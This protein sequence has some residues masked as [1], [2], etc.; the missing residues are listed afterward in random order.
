MKNFITISLYFSFVS[1]LFAQDEKR[2]YNLFNHAKDDTVAIFG[3]KVNVRTDANKDAKVAEQLFIGQKVIILE[4]TTAIMTVSDRTDAWYMVSYGKNLNEKTGF[5]WGGVFAVKFVELKNTQFVMNF[6]ESQ[7]DTIAGTVEIRAASE[8][9]MLSSQKWEAL[10]G[11]EDY[12]TTSLSGSKGLENYTNIIYFSSQFDACGYPQ[13][14]FFGLWDEKKLVALPTVAS[15]ADGGFYFTQTYKFPED[16][17]GQYNRIML[18]EENGRPLEDD[19][20]FGGDYTKKIREVKWN[21]KK[22]VLPEIKWEIND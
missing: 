13:H 3:D 2:I 10:I 15:M 17:D 7:I 22:Y 5:I 14:E 1:S 6:I 21:G 20:E 19:N 9:K 4:K 8:G 12:A 16:E 18:A 11:E